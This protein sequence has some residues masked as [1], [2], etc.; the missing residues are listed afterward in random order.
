MTRKTLPPHLAERIQF[1]ANPGGCWRWIGGTKLCGKI[2]V[3]YTRYEG[4]SMTARRAVFLHLHGEPGGPLFPW[5][6]LDDCVNPPH[7][8]TDPRRTAGAQAH[9]DR[10]RT[11][12]QI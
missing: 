4:R 6:G 10:K 2:R 9:Q 8:T 5:C 3:G 1:P 12:K 11:S 7:M